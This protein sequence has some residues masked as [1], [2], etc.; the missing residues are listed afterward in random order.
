[1]EFMFGSASSFNSN[2]S[3]WNV[4]SVT[5]MEGMFLGASSFNL[6]ISNW[7]VGLVTDMGGMFDGASSFNSNISNWNVSAVTYMRQ[8]FFGASSFNSHISNWNVSA[9]ENMMACSMR[10]QTLIKT[11]VIGVPSC[12]LTSIMA[13]KLTCF[14]FLDVPTKPSLQDVQDPGVP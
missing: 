11:S 13:A 14:T 1:M 10:H 7:N 12:Q 4:S 5:N 2:I 8:M 6:N 3:N 9:V